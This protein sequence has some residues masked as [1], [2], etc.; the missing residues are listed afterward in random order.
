MSHRPHKLKTA[1]RTALMPKPEPESICQEAQRIVHG[2]RR[3]GYGHPRKN[4]A[5][6]AA[7]W[8]VI[9]GVPVTPQQV[10]LCMIG[11]KLCRQVKKNNRD[12][13]V[14]MCGYALCHELLAETP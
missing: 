4:F 13:L 1:G 14:D 7:V 12:N 8:S 9:L 5:D 6:T 2:P 11:V 10:A 3:D